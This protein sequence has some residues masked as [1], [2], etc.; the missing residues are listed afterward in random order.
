MKRLLRKFHSLYKRA[1]LSR[2]YST[3]GKFFISRLSS[4]V[5]GGQY[6]SYLKSIQDGAPI[7]TDSFQYKILNSRSFQETWLNSSNVPLMSTIM[8]V[9][10]ENPNLRTCIDLGSGTGWVSNILSEKF[11]RVVAIEPSDCAIEISKHYFGYGYSS[12]IEWMQGF[13]EEIL[14]ELD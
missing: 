9:I 12:N 13:A 3:T 5:H 6:E 10:S 7:D 8:N 1:L 11:A 4:K 14:P 2:I